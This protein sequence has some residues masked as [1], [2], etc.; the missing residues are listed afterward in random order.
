[1]GVEPVVKI[2]NGLGDTLQNLSRLLLNEVKR[3]QFGSLRVEKSE[4]PIRRRGSHRLLRFARCFLRADRRPERRE[5]Q[6]DDQILSCLHIN[7]EP[8]EGSL[9]LKRAE[10]VR[11]RR[12]MF[13]AL[14]ASVHGSVR[15]FDKLRMTKR[16]SERVG[17]V[18][19]IDSLATAPAPHSARRAWR[20]PARYLLFQ[21]SLGTRGIVGTRGGFVRILRKPPESRRTMKPEPIV[22]HP[23]SL[24][25]ILENS[26]ERFHTRT[27]AEGN[28]FWFFAVP[29]MLMMVGLVI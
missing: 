3:L 14:P 2:R 1:M 22:P 11:S 18:R 25:V 27:R 8:V 6:Q 7:H 16:A 4:L 15:F 28:D 17:A 21:G 12:Q 13:F 5:K 19:F 23:H 9:T 10:A 20:L 26:A 24:V 29:V